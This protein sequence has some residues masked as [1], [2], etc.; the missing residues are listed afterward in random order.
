MSVSLQLELDFKQQ[1]QQ[2]QFSPQNVDWQQLCLAFDAAIA[3][4]PLSQQLA[5]AAD[6]IWELA[7]VFVL[8]AEAWF[9]ELR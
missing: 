2:A 1:L 6:A 9:E 7:E 5:L 3:Q 8:R 4:T